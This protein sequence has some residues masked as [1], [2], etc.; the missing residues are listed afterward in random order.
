MLF[1]F[2]IALTAV[3]VAGWITGARSQTRSDDY[4]LAGR[5]YGP[6]VIGLSAGAAGNSGFLMVGSVGLGYLLGPSAFTLLL[7]VLIGDWCFWTWLA[8]RV[9][10]ATPAETNTVPERIAQATGSGQGENVRRVAAVILLLCLCVYATAQLDAIGMSVSRAF[11][12]D[13]MAAVVGYVILVGSYTTFGGFRSSVTASL[14][15][16]LIMLATALIVLVAMAN[17]LYDPGLGWH[18]VREAWATSIAMAPATGVLDFV[19][20]I[21]G[22]IAF[23]IGIG[24]GL[25]TILVKVFALQDGSATQRAKWVYISF[26]HGILAVMLLL[27]MALHVLVPGIDNP[28]LGLFEFANLSLHPLLTGLVLAGLVAAVS[29]TFESLL[30]VLSSAL[31]ADILGR[32]IANLSKRARKIVRLLITATVVLIITALTGFN[33]ASVFNL[34]IYSISCLV[35]SF[36]PVIV[37]ATFGLRTSATALV[38]TMITG[39]AVSL[40]WIAAGLE[41]QFNGVMPAFLAA[42]VV[43][44][45]TRGSHRRSG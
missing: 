9:H 44:N 30:V 33:S 18:G 1:S 21:A 34:V 28:E 42:L 22:Y 3:M 5:S 29:S 16:G 25:P 14:I 26:T 6:L 13:K 2:V 40:A 17:A 41:S 8:R 27:G 23:G 7:G 15:H 20:Q 45:L 39:F 38:W 32:R 10:D 31:G 24:L 35:A 19:V 37:I 36:A 11:E 12:I 4:Y 43:N